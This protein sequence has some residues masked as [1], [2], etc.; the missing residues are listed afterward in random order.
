MTHERDEKHF[1][2]TINMKNETKHDTKDFQQILKKFYFDLTN[3]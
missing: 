2:L 1:K 3:E